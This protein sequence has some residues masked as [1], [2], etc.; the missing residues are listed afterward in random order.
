MLGLPV[1]VA[2]PGEYVADG[3]ARQAAWVLSGAGEPA[4]WPITDGAVE[5]DTP[6][7]PELRQRYHAAAAHYLDQTG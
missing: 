3:A 6:A 2:D 7:T 4:Q 5:F 1:L